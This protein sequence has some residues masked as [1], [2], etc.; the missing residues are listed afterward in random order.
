M[1]PP[2]YREA[3]LQLLH[4]GHQG[5]SHMKSLAKLHVW[6]PFIDDNIESFVK[7][8]NSCAETAHDPTEVPLHQ[9]D[10]PAKP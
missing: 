4:E 5:M 7:A 3:V 9:W 1:I 2:Q 8:C 6:W 10:I